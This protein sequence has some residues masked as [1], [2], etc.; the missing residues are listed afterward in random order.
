MRGNRRQS[1]STS[2]SRYRTAERQ[3]QPAPDRASA[4][5]KP[6]YYDK[7]TYG[8][9]QD[10]GAESACTGMQR[11]PYP[12]AILIPP[13]SPYSVIFLRSVLRWIPR[14]SAA[15]V[16]LFPVSRMARRM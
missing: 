16:R 13:S 9:S 1:D 4:R 2:Q 11:A 5:K 7:S 8:L 14:R 15:S 3:A 6:T 10:W 12:C